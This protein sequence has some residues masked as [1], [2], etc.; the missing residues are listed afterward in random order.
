MI[1][2]MR[3][4]V[5]IDLVGHRLAPNCGSDKG[6]GGHGRLAPRARIIIMSVYGSGGSAATADS[7]DV[8][9][10]HHNRQLMMWSWKQGGR[11][12]D[13]VVVRRCLVEEV[14]DAS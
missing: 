9:V 2:H 8:A 4:F 3:L 6:S 13:E 14:V 11:I 10:A 1:V 7:L 12:D 5:V